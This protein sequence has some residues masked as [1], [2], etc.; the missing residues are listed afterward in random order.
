MKHNNKV[1]MYSG[2]NKQWEKEGGVEGD[3]YEMKLKQQIPQLWAIHK[4]RDSERK[5]K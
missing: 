3:I 1:R 5:E 4:K 2:C